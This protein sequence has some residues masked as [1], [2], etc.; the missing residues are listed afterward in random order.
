MLISC[1][2]IAGSNSTA[3]VIRMTLLSLITNPPVYNKLVSEIRNASANVN[4]PISWP[5]TQSMPYLKAVIREGLRMWPPVAGL[6]SKRVPDGGD[7]ISGYFVPGGTEIGQGY[8]AVGRSQEIWGPDANV[9]RPERWLV[10][11][12]DRNLDSDREKREGE[13]ESGQGWDG[14]ESKELRRLAAAVDT[15]FGGGKY[16][17]LGKPIALMEL[18]KAVFEVGAGFCS[19]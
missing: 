17:C 12:R 19:L 15:H 13:E 3:H 11:T 4:S 16:S 9:F 5:Q 14:G 7:Y 8:H 10:V 18:H 6:G 1:H 2:R